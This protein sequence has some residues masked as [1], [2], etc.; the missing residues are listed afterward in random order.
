MSFGLARQAVC[1]A[2]RNILEAPSE[3]QSKGIHATL[4]MFS[5]QLSASSCPC[6]ERGSVNCDLGEIPPPQKPIKHG[7]FP[8]STT[9]QSRKPALK[10]AIKKSLNWGNLCSDCLF[11]VINAGSTVS[12]S[13]ESFMQAGYEG[14]SLIP[15][16]LLATWLC[17][18]SS[19]EASIPSSLSF[20][21]EILCP[22]PWCDIL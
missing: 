8:S 18:L 7:T 5:H 10:C 17:F 2:C 16:G 3:R 12:L 22:F 1:K 21:G 15:P 13:Q 4:S 14:L 20:Q 11:R 6:T 19:E 9:G